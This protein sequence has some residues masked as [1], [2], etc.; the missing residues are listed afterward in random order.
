MYLI[1]TEHPFSYNCINLAHVVCI[2]EEKTRFLPLTRKPGDL[3]VCLCYII[4]LLLER[5]ID[6][7]E[8]SIRLNPRVHELDGKT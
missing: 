2:F 4:L 6:L 8:I 7:Y 3:A 5:R 1:L